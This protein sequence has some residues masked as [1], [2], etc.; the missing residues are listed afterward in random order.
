MGKE[1]K[2]IKV[3][4]KSADATINLALDTI[5]MG[6]QALVFVN[7][8]R[9][10][11]RV[12][13]DL[14]KKTGIKE[15]ALER[16]GEF[17]HTSLPRPTKQ[18]ER[19]ARC[20]KGGVAFHHAG[21][22]AEQR[23]AIE[24]A[25]RDNTVRI[26]CCTP[27]LAAGVD[28][29]AFR[30]IIRDVRRY[31][32]RGMTFIPVLEY[33]Q[34]AGRS[35]RPSFDKKGEA[36]IVT[37]NEE[38]KETLTERYIHGDPEEIYSK[39]AVEPVLRTYLLSLIASGFITSISSMIAFFS[40]TFWA[41]QYEDP[42]AL[43]A[44]L[45]A[46]LDLLEEWEFVIQNGD[47]NPTSNEPAFVSADQ[48]TAEGNDK[49]RTTLMGKRISQLYLDPLTAYQLIERIRRT[50]T[51]K[52]DTFGLLHAFSYTLEMR[53]LLHMRNADFEM[54]EDALATHEENML[55][56]EPSMA[57]IDIDEFYD[58]VK[59][60]LFLSEWIEEKDEEYLLEKYAVRPGETRVKI[61]TADW[62]LFAMS[63]IAKIM[64]YRDLAKPLANLRTRLKYGAREELL[65]LLRIRNIGRVRAR[66]LFFH[67][68]K[69]AGSLRRTDKATLTQLLGKATATTIK[70]QL[71]QEDGSVE[72]PK[73]KRRGQ[74]SLEDW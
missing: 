55:E 25:F 68:I 58:S 40:K 67:G 51:V 57:S 59:T 19:L 21:L 74:I 48:L 13:E 41:H 28:L 52:F 4:K 33:L 63:E 62:L 34:M 9:S 66:K 69:D 31:T 49:L 64:S 29:P 20:I 7:T 43:T 27:T 56:K 54:V 60:A 12:A 8:K 15:A 35:G 61:S 18:C 3:E 10:A 38:E 32:G 14:S 23:E 26:I 39:L 5:A 72:V 24:D 36:I 16:L 11:E 73:N 45:M 53:P 65:P 6:K 1:A 42:D 30:T 50:T 71:G 37:N 22:V 17:V 46:T 70:V 2:P 47:K 44:K